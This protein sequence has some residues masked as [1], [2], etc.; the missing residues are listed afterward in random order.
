MKWRIPKVKTCVTTF[1]GKLNLQKKMLDPE[2]IYI[3]RINTLTS[4]R[5]G[6]FAG[7]PE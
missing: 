1:K 3:A 7:L 2:G 6:Q 4:G 5:V